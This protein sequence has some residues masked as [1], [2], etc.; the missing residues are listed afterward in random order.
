[1]RHQAVLTGHLHFS[2]KKMEKQMKGEGSDNVN[3]QNICY[4]I[5]K[6]AKGSQD[7]VQFSLL[8]LPY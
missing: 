6:S 4:I 1:M 2:N 3:W 5:I 8:L 7:S